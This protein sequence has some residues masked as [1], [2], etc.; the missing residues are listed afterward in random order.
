MTKRLKIEGGV[1]RDYCFYFKPVYIALSFKNMYLY[2]FV[3][4]KKIMWKIGKNMFQN[5][6]SQNNKISKQKSGF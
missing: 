6:P 1:M 4:N 3:T 2:Y 5:V